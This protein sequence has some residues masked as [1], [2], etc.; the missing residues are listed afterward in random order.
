VSPGWPA[1]DQLPARIEHLAR[2]PGGGG[3]QSGG[4][5]GRHG[6]RNAWRN[7]DSGHHET[8]HFH[9]APNDAFGRCLKYKL[10][11]RLFG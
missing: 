5:T 3:D 1:L 7:K 6:A 4:R 10:K 2:R 8:L 11:H 9:V